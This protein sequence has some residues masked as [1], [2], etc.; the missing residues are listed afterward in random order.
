MALQSV[1]DIGPN[2]QLVP[3]SEAARVNAAIANRRLFD[4]DLSQ[5]KIEALD[6]ATPAMQFN[7]FR[8]VATFYPEFMLA[9]RPAILVEGNPRMEAAI[10]DMSR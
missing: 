1:S 5:L 3:N 10:E 9:E 2:K 4:G 8:R 6:N 7:W